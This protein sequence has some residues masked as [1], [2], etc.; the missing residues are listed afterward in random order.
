LGIISQDQT[1]PAG[2]S[3]CAIPGKILIIANYWLDSRTVA[4]SGKQSFFEPITLAQATK[5][6]GRVKG[7]RNLQDDADVK[8]TGEVSMKAMVSIIAV[9]LLSGTIVAGTALSRSPV[10][11]GYLNIGNYVVSLPQQLRAGD[12]ILFTNL[13]GVRVL[14]QR[15]NNGFFNLDV[16]RLH[17]GVYIM[18]VRRNGAD[19]TQVR[20]PF[21]AGTGA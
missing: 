5:S 3:F 17:A 7:K 13:N 1:D 19:I 11:K 8:F 14:D 21:M 6:Y 10:Y 2:L 20:V 15:V 4:L 9:A 16:S 18:S 12:R